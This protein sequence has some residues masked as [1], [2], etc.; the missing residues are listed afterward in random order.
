MSLE[1]LLQKVFAGER[2]SPEELDRLR[3]GPRD[4]THALA[5]AHALLEHEAAR[6][7]LPLLDTLARERPREVQIQLARARALVL[8]ERHADADRAAQ[9]ALRLNPDDPEAMKTLAALALRRGEHAR[10]RA[11]VDGV[12]ERDPFDAEAQLLKAELEAPSPAP[13]V[14]PKL[15]WSDFAIKLALGLKQV[16]VPARRQGRAL[17]LRLGEGEVGRADL[18]AL[19]ARYLASARTGEEA[20][21]E[22]VA[23][24]TSLGRQGR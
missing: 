11:W 9:E 3:A 5:L 24:L 10:A 18:D 15:D 17:L 14:R 20:V 7:A 2:L 19:H 13:A 8:L 1:P 22:L 21:A 16:G 12:L 4:F 6:E 23:E